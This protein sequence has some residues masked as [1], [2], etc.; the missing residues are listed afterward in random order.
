MIVSVYS[1]NPTDQMNQTDQTHQIDQIDQ[2]ESQYVT[3]VPKITFFHLTAGLKVATI[4]EKVATKK[5]SHHDQ[6]WN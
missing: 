2:I 6:C 4:I 5:E 1:L 3:D